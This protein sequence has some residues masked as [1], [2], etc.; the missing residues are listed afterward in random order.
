MSFTNERNTVESAVRETVVFDEDQ[1]DGL[2]PGLSRPGLSLRQSLSRPL[3]AS[4]ARLINETPEKRA[5]RLARM[6]AYSKR[7]REM[8]KQGDGNSGD[9]DLNS[10]MSDQV[11]FQDVQIEQCDLDMNEQDFEDQQL[12]LEE[13]RQRESERADE[14]GGEKERKEDESF[15]QARVAGSHSDRGE[16][17][18]QA[19]SSASAGGDYHTASSGDH[20]AAFESSSESRM[21]PHGSVSADAPIEKPPRKRAYKSKKRSHGAFE[22]PEQ[23][24]QA[25]QA[26]EYGE[27]AENEIDPSLADRGVLYH[28]DDADNHYPSRRV[29]PDYA[30]QPSY[31]QRSQQAYQHADDLQDQQQYQ[32]PKQHYQPQHHHH[33]QQ[34]QQQQGERGLYQSHVPDSHQSRLSITLAPPSQHVAA[35]RAPAPRQRKP[36]TE[37]QRQARRAKRSFDGESPEQREFRLARMRAYN[38]RYTHFIKKGIR[39]PASDSAAAAAAPVALTA[40][41]PRTPPSPG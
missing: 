27:H 5:E 34:Q 29:Y 35:A 38:H 25:H 2:Y 18:Q 7:R 10:S 22:K 12:Y 26:Y 30:D 14:V 39:V 24:Y 3:S 16:S 32:Q 6:R 1:N 17:H 36:R 11:D 31:V 8:K 9:L 28:S 23:V 21:P 13:I 41:S 40:V 4:R 20:P 33:H 19:F 37:Q 15:S